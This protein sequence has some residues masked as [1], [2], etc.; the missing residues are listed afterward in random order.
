MEKRIGGLF[1]AP[2]FGTILMSVRRFLARPASV[3]LEA[4]GLFGPLPLAMNR[5]R[6][7]P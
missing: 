4:T 5:A 1:Y 6:L 3:A 2:Y 7:N